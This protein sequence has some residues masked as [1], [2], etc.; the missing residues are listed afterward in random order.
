MALAEE[1]FWRERTIKLKRA[2]ACMLHVLER[3][4]NDDAVVVTAIAR[5]DANQLIRFDIDEGNA[6]R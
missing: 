3:S 6:A 4:R 5:P 1:Q 2:G